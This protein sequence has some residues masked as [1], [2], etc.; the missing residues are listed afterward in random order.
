MDKRCS[1]PEGRKRFDEGR[2]VVVGSIAVIFQ[3]RLSHTAYL[4][5]W[6]SDCTGLRRATRIACPPTVSQAMS[7][8]AMPLVR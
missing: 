7:R 1:A 2:M 8:M 5:S 6:R 4:Y 3:P